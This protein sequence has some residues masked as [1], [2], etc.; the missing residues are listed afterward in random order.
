MS[1]GHPTPEKLRRA[2][3]RVFHDAGLSYVQIVRLLGIGE[4]TVISFE[5]SSFNPMSKRSSR[6]NSSA[7]LRTSSV[8]CHDGGG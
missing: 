2:I 5:A 1:K 3:V 8:S 7:H 6:F 4:A